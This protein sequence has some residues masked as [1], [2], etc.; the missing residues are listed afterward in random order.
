ML[1]ERE[2]Y[3]EE[4]EYYANGFYSRDLLTALGEVKGLRVPLVRKGIFLNKVSAKNR[5]VFMIKEKRG[6]SYILR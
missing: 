2:I 1:E 6:A 3:L 5:K 4:T